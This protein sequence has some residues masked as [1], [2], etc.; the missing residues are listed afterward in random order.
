MNQD[1]CFLLG[2]ITKPFSFKGEVVLWM[3]VDD[4]AAYMDVTT[5]WIPQQSIL[6]PYAVESIK[7]NKDR[8]VVRLSDV[9]TEDQAKGLAGKDVWLPL[10]DMAPLPEGKF[11]FHEVQGWTAVDRASDEAVGTILH[12]V[13]HGAYPM[14]EVDFGEGN[15]GFIPLPEHVTI[16]VKRDAQTLVL[17]L[18]D[19][20]LDVYLGKDDP[21]MDGDDDWEVPV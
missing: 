19:G 20:L 4:K 7:V 8:F 15:T 10:S 21:E 18:P 2:K 11:Y 14:L 3:D 9:N 6:V 13:D 16:D 17:D 1:Q 12:V 5:L